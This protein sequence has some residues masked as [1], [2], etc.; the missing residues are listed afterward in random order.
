MQ[1]IN[2]WTSEGPHAIQTSLPPAAP[3][4]AANRVAVAA[5]TCS[6]ARLEGPSG[7]GGR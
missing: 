4:S 2:F 1:I 3:E 7:G 6:N 5:V